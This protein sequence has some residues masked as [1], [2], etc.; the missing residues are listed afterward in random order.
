MLD[1]VAIGY[2]ARL[3]I[4]LTLSRARALDATA[5]QIALWDGSLPMAAA[6]TAADVVMW[7][8]LGKPTVVVPPPLQR[9]A[10]TPPRDDTGE[11]PAHNNEIAILFADFAGYSKLNELDYG[12]FRERILRPIAGILNAC[13]PALLH[14]NTWGDGLYLVFDDCVVAA[15]CALEIRDF[16]AAVDWAELGL[17]LR[18]AVRIGGHVGPLRIAE[19]PI[20]RQ[21]SFSGPHV[22]RAA[23]IEPIAPPGEV[24]VTEAFAAFLEMHG[25]TLLRVEYV[26]RR[27]TAKQY[28]EMRLFRLNSADQ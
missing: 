27:P 15:R 19:D 18:L 22:V 6:G 13:G 23:R 12:I 11:S 5:L 14:R 10:A 1:D 2:G 4:G 21:P 25:A 20:T 7:R 24:F 28:G 8:R 9:E 26:G 16:I 17:S 3:A